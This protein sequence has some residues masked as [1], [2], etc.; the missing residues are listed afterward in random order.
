MVTGV[1]CRGVCLLVFVCALVC[2][3]GG[4]LCLMAQI[5]VVECVCLCVCVCLLVSVGASTC[6]SILSVQ[7][8]ETKY[9]T[10]RSLRVE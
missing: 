1:G 4:W 10:E 5:V 8:R 3:F 7:K 6:P 9:R 2:C